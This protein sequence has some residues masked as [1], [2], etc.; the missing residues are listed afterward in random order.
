MSELYFLPAER[1]QYQTRPVVSIQTYLVQAGREAGLIVNREA[2]HIIRERKKEK[3]GIFR[4]R[5][6]YIIIFT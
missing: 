2:E 6:E 4:K 3:R 1:F 5:V